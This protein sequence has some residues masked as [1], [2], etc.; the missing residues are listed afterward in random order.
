MDC[1]NID[2]LLASE[3][4]KSCQNIDFLLQIFGNFSSNFAYNIVRK[5][6][7]LLSIISVNFIHQIT[8]DYNDLFLTLMTSNEF[9]TKHINYTFSLIHQ[10]LHPNLL[11]PYCP[12]FRKIYHKIFL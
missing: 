9:T 6:R 11:L 3:C 10:E 2:L 8:K 1:Q 4:M 5:S 7:K 12:Q